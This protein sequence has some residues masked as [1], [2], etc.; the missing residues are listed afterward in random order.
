MS[1]WIVGTSLRLRYLILVLAA[2]LVIFGILQVRE[3]AV[4]V[5]PEFNPPLVEIQT[6]ALGLSAEEIEALL[7]VPLEADLLNG[8][9]W[10]DEIYS[11]SVSG[12][13]SILLIFEPGTD[14]IRARQMVQER[15]TQTFALPNVSRPP[16]MLQPL[17]TTN[18]V[19]MVGL[20]SDQ[21][22]L[23]DM[24]V[25][26]RWNIAPRLLGVPGV[27]NVAIW[28]Q[29]EWQLQVLVDPDVLRDHGVT[30]DQ[31]VAASGEALWVSPLSY[32]EASSPGTAGWI[33]TPNQRLTIRHELPIRSAEDMATIPIPGTAWKLGDVAQLAENHQ[34]LIGDA[35]LENGT[36]LIL[37]IEKFPGANTLEVTEGVENALKSM[38][39]GLT[40][41]DIN[42]NVYRSS[43]YIEHA[44]RNLGT[45][46]AV[47][48]LLVILV[49]G[50]FFYE[51][52]SALISLVAIVLALIGAVFVLYLQ[53]ATLN[54]MILAGLAIALGVVI[55]DAIVDVDLIRSRLKADREG[56]GETPAAGIILDTATEMRSMMSV[57][58]VILLVAILPVFFLPQLSRAFLQP[59]SVTY[60]IAVLASLAIAL[61][62]TPTLSV[63]L[64]SNGKTAPRTSPVV[65]GLRQSYEQ[66]LHRIT[67]APRATF[68]IGSL[69]LLAAL[70]AIPFLNVS[71]LPDLRQPN[72]RI[73]WEG[74][75]S[76]SRQE[77]SRI[78]AR[79]AA[80]LSEISG[81][82]NVGSH[83]GRAI[84]GDQVVGINS[85]ELWL[86]LDPEA[87]Y[88]ST[89]SA[90]RE[91]IA[92]YPGLFRE[93]SSYQPERLKEVLSPG[94]EGLTVRVYGHEYDVLEQT[95][96]NVKGRLE[97]IEGVGS[98]EVEQ[99]VVE[100]QV[101]IEVDLAAA[102]RFQVKPG[103]I[104]R[105]ATTLLSGL[106][107]GNL[108]EEQK[109]FE[110]VV[111]GVP[112]IRGNMTDVQ[113]LLV[114]TPRGGHVLLGEVAD[115]RIV[116]APT[117]IRR[118]AVSRY[119]DV[120]VIVSGRSPSAVVAD[121]Q[122]ALDGFPVPFEYHV[123]VLGSFAEQQQARQQVWAA[124][125]IVMIGI[126][127]LLRAAYDSFP[128]AFA[129]MLSWP[130]AISGGVLAV[131]L[132]D[133]GSL[134][135]GSIFGF[136]TVFGVAVRTSMGLMLRSRALQDAGSE[137]DADLAIR[138]A[139]ERMRPVLLTVLTLAL[140]MV[141]VIVAGKIAGLEILHP[142]AV[143]VLGGTIST[144]FINLLV[145]PV[146]FLRYGRQG[147]AVKGAQ[148]G[149]VAPGV[150]AD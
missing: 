96:Q 35:V 105:S 146:L 130:F 97:G 32:L 139:L 41:I 116:P 76:T 113:N 126:F 49:L 125:V 11:E 48:A 121:I 3:M 102:D 90:I 98:I 122:A 72:L 4:D 133:G 54:I 66:L 73:Q 24:S 61:L 138:A 68:V 30:L 34:P 9:A 14:P 79:V 89:I 60:I 147:E 100:P 44:S 56:G 78:S 5:Y 69:A 8:V 67:Q 7:T 71:L 18:R 141:P 77:M 92:G 47:S 36:G 39:A 28:G 46:L 21:V 148:V 29:R 143:V 13:S 33:D 93:V 110:V 38:Q 111:W 25:L 37:V 15:L 58:T 128:L 124:A 137:H 145:L 2:V 19:M 43:N 20:S 129:T 64:L 95:A 83:V 6:E 51:W 65:D 12:L 81:V 74:P 150:G 131:F 59:L 57:G 17:S 101:E 50:A 112:E 53:G 27:A 115:I 107:V 85:A 134:S 117:V 31:V 62:V 135:L 108:Y 132:L 70:V 119:M 40:G 23:I 88:D 10:L 106:Q 42:T 84:T 104:R 52:R 91:V 136:L 140:A 109:V 82:F 22:S 114:D 118:D 127:L 26:A 120:H 103:D 149:A 16:T 94:A 75:P 87:D 80:E 55:D 63:V 45:T 86:A 99:L 142:I 144:A 1:Q 123:N